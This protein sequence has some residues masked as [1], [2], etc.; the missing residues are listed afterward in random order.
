MSVSTISRAEEVNR[1]R[2]I[3]EGFEEKYNKLR[4]LALKLKKKVA[5]QTSII[6]TLESRNNDNTNEGVQI[7]SK[8]GVM[9]VQ[10][11]NLQLLQCENDRLLDELEVVKG[12]WKRDQLELDSARTKLDKVSNE[13]IEVK[14]SGVENDAKKVNSSQAIKEYLKQ[15]Q[16]LKEENSEN[17]VIKK[18]MENE[19]IK[20]KGIRA[21]MTNPFQKEKKINFFS[22]EVNAKD[23]EIN[24]LKELEKSLRA[25]QTRIKMSLKQTN[26]LSLEMDAYEKSLNET[27]QK[28]EAMNQQST[29][30]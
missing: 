29:E 27:T 25:E 22:D 21:K 19:L 6:Q 18:S 17:M 11:K 5:E 30:V 8:L 26:V 12:N 15:I 16:G 20:L 10:V 9:E 23:K 1:M 24:S 13:L 3:E 2:D 4:A 7:S 28:L 14:S